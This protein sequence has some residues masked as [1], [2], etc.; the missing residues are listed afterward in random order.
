MKK[1][2]VFTGSGISAE[3]GIKTFRD[4][5]GLWEK[6]DIK[7]V[8]TPEAWARN[9][10]LVQEFYNQRRKQI[11]EASPNAAHK[12][13]KQLETKFNTVIVTQNV[14]DL[15]E[16]AGSANI[17]HLHGIITKSQSSR[18]P[19]LV[20]PIEGWELSMNATCEYG[21]PLRPHIVWFGE[22]VPEM[23]RAIYEVSTADYFIVIGTSLEVYPA[24]SLIH[25]TGDNTTTYLIDP[26]ARNVS[27]ISNI[28]IIK[29]SAGSAVPALVN[30]LLL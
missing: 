15:H 2:V 4:S 21:F 3:S 9:P 27:G 30:R 26:A 12:A 10:Q 23:D 17:I 11:L 20:Y 13:L 16:R 19:E 5:D 7:T 24:A 18:F 14:D 1:V 22:P 6:Y 29:E 8:A 25:F 28:E